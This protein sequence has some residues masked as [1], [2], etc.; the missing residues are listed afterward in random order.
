LNYIIALSSSSNT[1]HACTI[2]GD[3]DDLEAALLQQALLAIWMQKGQQA[4]IGDIADWLL[5]REDA[6][7]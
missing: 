5:A 3:V 1:L 6:G 7:G 2:V 4:T